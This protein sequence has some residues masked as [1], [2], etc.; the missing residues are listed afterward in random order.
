MAA[1]WVTAK[2]LPV[3][4]ATMTNVISG[5]EVH[6]I[7]LLPSVDLKVK[8]ADL[9][10]RSAQFVTIDWV[11]KGRGQQNQFRLNGNR[12]PNGALTSHSIR[13]GTVT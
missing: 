5:D 4:P 1:V 6:G 11:P 7:S 12:R 13:I 10:S 3:L 2:C 9:F 8:L